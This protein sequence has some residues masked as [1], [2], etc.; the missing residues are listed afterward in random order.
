MGR[1]WQLDGQLPK[2]PLCLRLCMCVCLC[3]CICTCI[4]QNHKPTH[5]T[6]EVL[7]ARLASADFFP[8]HMN[9]YLSLYLS[10]KEFLYLYFTK[11][12]V[13]THNTGD[14]DG[15]TSSHQSFPSVFF[16]FV[17]VSV[18]VNEFVFHSI[19]QCV[20]HTGGVDGSTGSRRL[21]SLGSASPQP[22]DQP[23]LV[24]D[25]RA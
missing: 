21:R 23:V 13:Q 25:V 19:S 14:V 12:Q 11:S 16:V 18:F 24:E 15:S 4:S 17:F 3:L 20:P 2:Y 7:T 6:Q 5:N 9:L 22:D 10:S 1:F 8:V